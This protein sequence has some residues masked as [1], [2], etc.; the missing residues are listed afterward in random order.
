MVY[1]A[2]GAIYQSVMDRILHGLSKTRCYIDDII[3]GGTDLD[4][5]KR[6]LEK[7]FLQRLSEHNV[8]INVSKCSFFKEQISYLGHII[9]KHGLRPN[10]KKHIFKAHQNQRTNRS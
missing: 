5:C 9:S 7:V 2:P 10:M 1:H 3:V 8:N 4:D 6:N